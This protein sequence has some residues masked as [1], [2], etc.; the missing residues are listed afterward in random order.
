MDVTVPDVSASL[1]EVSGD[2]LLP[3]CGVDAS[4]P[5][6]SGSLPSLSADVSLPSVDADM[7]SSSMDVPCVGGGVPGSL[8]GIS[9][10]MSAPSADMDT[11]SGSVDIKMPTVCLA[12]K[13]PDIPP[14]EGH[15]SGP[16]PSADVKL[17]APKV[18]VEGSDVS[19]TASLAAGATAGVGAIGAGIGLVAKGD[20]PKGEVR[21]GTNT[22]NVRPFSRNMYEVYLLIYNDLPFL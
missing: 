5:D 20:K 22:T 14:A 1:S 11:P 18:E 9:G 21:E 15:L 2:A 4:V 8:P 16:I 13:V 12:G 7:P 10:D 6:V 3:P 19:L 17:T